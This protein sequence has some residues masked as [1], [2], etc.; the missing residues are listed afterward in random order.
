M[1]V[2][3]WRTIPGMM[4]LAERAARNGLVFSQA[5]F[6]RLW[7]VAEEV[8]VP[9]L[10]MLA[11]LP[12]EGT[13][14]FNT[15][16]TN[17]AADGGHGIES[18]WEKDVRR[19]VDLVAGKLALWPQAVSQGWAEMSE[20][21]VSPGWGGN[22]NRADGNPDIW[23]NWTTAIL[24][25]SGAVNIGA[26]AVHGSWWLGVRHNLT[27]YGGTM[28]QLIDAAKK[29]DKRAPRVSMAFRYV[30]SDRYQASDSRGVTPEPAVVCTSARVTA[31]APPPEPEKP[32]TRLVPVMINGG[33]KRIDGKTLMGEWRDDQRVWISIEGIWVP[34][35]AWAELLGAIVEWVGPEQGGPLVRVRSTANI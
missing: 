10:F 25:P 31:P 17:K 32:A 14:S 18:D 24:R 2:P 34:I 4:D 11:I 35:R 8:G 3:D 21:V 13:G 7:T 29:L 12:Q 23:V 19:A 26:Y 16:P 1:S 27:R 15:S 28:D 30:D 20:Q 33:D 22:R 6:E 9:P 5:R